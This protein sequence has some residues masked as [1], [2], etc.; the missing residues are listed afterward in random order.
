MRQEYQSFEDPSVTDLGR[1]QDGNSDVESLQT[2][3]ADSVAAQTSA[4]HV[5]LKHVFKRDRR[6]R[7]LATGVLPLLPFVVLFGIECV[8]GEDAWIKLCTNPLFVVVALAAC[9]ATPIWAL[10][11]SKRA[12]K[13]CSELAGVDDLTAIGSMIET[14]SYAEDNSRQVMETLIRLLPQLRASDA[15][16]ISAKQLLMLRSFL[17]TTGY[18]SGDLLENWF[19]K[20][21]DRARLQVA[22]LKAFEQI[23]DERVEQA[24]LHAMAHGASRDVKQAAAE[25]LPFVQERVDLAK[26]NRSLLRASSLNAADTGILVRPAGNPTH[27]DEEMLRPS[28]GPSSD[29]VEVARH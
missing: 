10:N 3:E 9:I 6:R 22:I 21:S 26:A 29:T 2:G 5:R 16:H 1:T 11:P 23:G 19:Q 27:L 24:V 20:R 8:I 14:V 18:A 28:T 15:Q 4:D 25:C 12:K 7:L 17:T 13:A